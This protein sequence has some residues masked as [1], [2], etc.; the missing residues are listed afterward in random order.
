MEWSEAVE[1]VAPH[2]VKVT[3]PGGSGT[4]FLIARSKK[5]GVVGIATAAHVVK[6]AHDLKQPIT[7]EHP[8]SGQSLVLTP[9]QRAVFL[10]QTGDTAALLFFP[11]DL[12]LPD[13]TS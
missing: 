6:E 7:I 11:E 5:A 1:Q 9:D 12:G 10:D 3:D 2:V 8:E 4:G 13:K